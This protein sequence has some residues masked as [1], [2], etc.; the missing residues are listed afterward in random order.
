MLLHV[1]LRLVSVQGEGSN[2]LRRERAH[3]AGLAPPP[4]IFNAIALQL[5]GPQPNLRCL[6]TL[7]SLQQSK[8]A[9]AASMCRGLRSAVLLLQQGRREK[10]RLR[11]PSVGVRM[12]QRSH[13]NL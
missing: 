1:A 5:Q 9:N 10:V 13:R 7:C 3:L 6:T 2:H 8:A 11:V 12:F 4:H